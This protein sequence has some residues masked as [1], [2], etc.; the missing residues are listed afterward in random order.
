MIN[1]LSALI[2]AWCLYTMFFDSS[3]YADYM[4]SSNESDSSDAEDAGE[5]DE[6]SEAEDEEK[7]DETG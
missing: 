1:I 4:G 3:A 5:D 7:T 2:Y 6:S